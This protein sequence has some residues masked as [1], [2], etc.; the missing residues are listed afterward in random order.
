M[1]SVGEMSFIGTRNLDVTS[2]ILTFGRRRLY[3]QFMIDA[4]STARQVFDLSAALV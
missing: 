2:L 1:V 4:V 3:E